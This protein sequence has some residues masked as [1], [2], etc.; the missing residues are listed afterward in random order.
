MRIATQLYTPSK[1]Q[2]V[3]QNYRLNVKKAAEKL[4]DATSRSHY[5][6]IEF[7][8]ENIIIE[9][10]AGTLLLVMDCFS[11]H[12]NTNSQLKLERTNK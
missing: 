8:H 7:K 1:T 11:N 4:I 2:L 9:F 12:F 10:S 5:S 3:L 6:K